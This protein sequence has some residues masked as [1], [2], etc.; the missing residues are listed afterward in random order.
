M[1]CFSAYSRSPLL[2]RTAFFASALLSSSIV[3]AQPAPSEPT[4]PADPAAAP[5]APTAAPAAEAA[6]PTAPAAE[7]TPASAPAPEA[8]PPAPVAE[9]APPAAE[10]AAPLP[11]AGKPKP[12]PYSLPF[13]LRP[14]VVGN[15]I[16]SDTA[17]AFFE[18]PA[19]GESGST[20]ASMLLASYKVTDELAP[21]IRLGLV[22]NSPPDAP[23]NP[24]SATG[25]LNPV[26]GATYAPKISPNIK[27]GL[28]LG[29]TIPIGSGGGNEPEPKNVLANGAGIRARSA[30]DNAMFA[31]ND[32]TVFPG[33][34]L[35]YTN[36][37][38]TAQV[39]ATLLQLTRV[40][41]DEPVVPDSSRTNFTT[42]LHVGYFVVPMLSL[43]AELR[44]QRWLSTPK[45]IENDT[46]DTL[47]DT[48]TVEFG[49]RL[50]VKIGEKS[51]F[52]PAIGYVIPLDDPMKDAK[53]KIIHLDLPFVI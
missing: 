51:W 52:R 2:L 49:P 38:F 43:A 5:A 12:P 4:P 44:H 39:E 14:V 37:G 32:F 48:T 34:G 16:R 36:A 18:N 8:P 33:V 46:T 29:V 10:P 1:T 26:L 35:A 30:M 31:V 11:E 23:T 3:C 28:F 47:R 13:Q 25:F 27:L 19:N 53:Y 50:H 22:S 21:M 42:G 9:V 17:I 6:P 24:E 41:G 40:K 15:V 7:P 45:A 20:V